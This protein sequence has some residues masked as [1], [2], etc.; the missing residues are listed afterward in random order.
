MG[1]LVRPSSG[2]A[3]SRRNT[4]TGNPSRSQRYLWI[5]KIEEASASLLGSSSPRL[6][7]HLLP[8][9]AGGKEVEGTS[10]KAEQNPRAGS[11]RVSASTQSKSASRI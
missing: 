9:R 10:S 3:A 2:R 6:A 8:H 11:A 4:D 1:N 5:T 7:P